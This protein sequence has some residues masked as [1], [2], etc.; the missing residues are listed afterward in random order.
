M[1]ENV[2]K[3]LKLGIRIGLWALFSPVAVP[4]I[5]LLFGM[6]GAIMLIHS[7]FILVKTVWI[8]LLEGWDGYNGADHYWENAWPDFRREYFR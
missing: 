2:K 6:M 5:A 3:N 8:I 1:E 4:F 7:L